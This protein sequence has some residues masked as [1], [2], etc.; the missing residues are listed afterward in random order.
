MIVLCAI[1]AALGLRAG[2]HIANLTETDVITAAVAD[3]ITHETALGQT[4]ADTDC[5]ATPGD[6][7]V[8]IVVTCVPLADPATVRTEYHISR[9]GQMEKLRGG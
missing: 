6:G 1:A 7:R 9:F 5:S 4:P 3:Y 2:W 8:W